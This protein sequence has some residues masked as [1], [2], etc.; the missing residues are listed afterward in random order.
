MSLKDAEIRALQPS[1]TPYKVSDSQGLYLQ[2]YPNGSKLWR[3]KFRYSSKE[4]LLALGAYP[5][6]TLANARSM[7][8]AAKAK[9]V[10]GIDPAADKKR[11]KIQK[12]FDSGN[13]F[14]GVG[15]EYIDKK[16]IG[17]RKAPAT[18][19]KTEWLLRLLTPA[20]GNLP[21]AEIEPVEILA[22]L[23][24]LEKAGKLETAR[25]CRAFASTVFRLSPVIIQ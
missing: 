4:K 17:E 11:K 12:L 23:R 18:I 6:V 19:S 5:G 24:K 13:S 15:R 1:D 22:P 3:Y 2:I 20:L 14:A 7:R 21:I 25:R 16:L 9:L 10:D 8:D